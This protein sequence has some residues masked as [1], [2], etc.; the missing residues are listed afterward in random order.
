MLIIPS[1]FLKELNWNPNDKLA[2]QCLPF[3]NVILIKNTGEQFP[4]KVLEDELAK[5]DE[6]YTPLDDTVEEN[7]S[8]SESGTTTD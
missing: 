5:L 6:N 1:V 3:D 4:E 2:V 7:E 8:L